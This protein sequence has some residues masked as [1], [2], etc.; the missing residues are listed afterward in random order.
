M[1]LFPNTE[2]VQAC[3]QQF[4]GPARASQGR[5]RNH[6]RMYRMRVYRMSVLYRHEK[7]Q[8]R[9][10]VLSIAPQGSSEAQAHT[11]NFLPAEAS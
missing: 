3:V 5:G 11:V 6:I 7:R 9:D 2:D 10:E 4:G 8:D 1:S